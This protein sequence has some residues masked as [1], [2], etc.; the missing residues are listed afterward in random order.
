MY[1]LYCVSLFV[2]VFFVFCFFFIYRVLTRAH[3]ELIT[4]WH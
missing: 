1:Y 3:A 2:W 4:K